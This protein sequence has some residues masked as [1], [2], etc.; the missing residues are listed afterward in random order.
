MDDWVAPTSRHLWVAAGWAALLDAVLLALV[1][2]FVRREVFSRLAWWLP[3]AAFLV[4]LLL[5]AVFASVLF[6]DEVYGRLF[7]AWARWLL[8][9]WMGLVFGAAALVFRALSLRLPGP[10]AVT[11]CLLGGISSLAGHGW[12]IHRGLLKVPFLS[13]VSAASAL[14]FGVFEFIAYWCLITALAAG[15]SGWLSTRERP[16]GGHRR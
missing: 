1:A 15:V 8:P 14:V 11:F 5:W 3:G 2:R 6:W 16:D 9:L 4:Y 13:R 12:G 7:A 10:P